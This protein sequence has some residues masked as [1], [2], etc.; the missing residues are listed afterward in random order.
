MD[1]P[2]TQDTSPVSD[3]LLPVGPA[4]RSALMSAATACWLASAVCII[5][6]AGRGAPVAW[7]VAWF[8]STAAAVAVTRMADIR[9]S[10]VTAAA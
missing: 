9:S 1:S 2:E 10:S 3:P 7:V 4:P 5:V 6:M 8:T